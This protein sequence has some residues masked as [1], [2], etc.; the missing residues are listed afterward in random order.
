MA[1][2]TPQ[3]ILFT[4]PESVYGRR[5]DWYFTLRAIKYSHCRVLNRLP[6]PVLEELN[7]NYRR[8]PIC[9][10]GRDIYCDTRL[11]IEKCEALISSNRL[12]A[13]TPYQKGISKLLETWTIDGGPFWRTAQLIPPNAPITRDPLWLEDRAEMSGRKWNA[14]VME[15]NRPE[16][17]AHSRAH[18]KIV[19]ELLMG[20][21]RDWVLGTPGP[22]LAD[23]HGIWPFDWAL[24]PY[25]VDFLPKDV[26][27]ES[28]FPRTFAW[29]KRF[30]AAVQEALKKNGSP[31]LLSPEETI[32]RIESAEY[33]EADGEIDPADPLRFEK[34]QIVDVF[35][36]DMASGF[37]HRD[38]GKLVN[39]SVMDVCLET[40]TKSGK[41]I[42][43]HFPRTNFRIAKA[44]SKL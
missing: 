8:I 40:K 7:V 1:T 2:S 13:N 27:S 22:T 43:I 16:A 35:P 32:G 34:G 10:I 42:R 41:D 29:V 44:V 6:R 19:E 14:R 23:I 36:T 12:G 25:M 28:V 20:D 31:K 11:I 26:I 30:N 9:A 37:V 33:F 15:E 3:I 24:Q 4:Y 5:I 38:T 18:F 21:G 39:V 17:L